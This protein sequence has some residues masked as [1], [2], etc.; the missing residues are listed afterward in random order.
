M[1]KDTPPLFP[2]CPVCHKPRTFTHLHTCCANAIQREEDKC[3]VCN[4]GLVIIQLVLDVVHNP[5][6]LN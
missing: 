5:Y 2:T 1:E 6:R 3:P 4:Q